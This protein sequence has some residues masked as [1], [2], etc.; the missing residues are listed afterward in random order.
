MRW[1]WSVSNR[2]QRIAQVS[3]TSYLPMK[4]LSPRLPIVSGQ[5]GLTIIAKHAG[6]FVQR[7][8]G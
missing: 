2:A 5:I 3:Q 4:L 6:S 7:K 8:A 1:S